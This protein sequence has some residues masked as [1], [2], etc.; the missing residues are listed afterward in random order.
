MT[1]MDAVIAL[2]VGVVVVLFVPAL[3]WSTV[4]AGLYRA[5]RD[6]LRGSLKA[7]ARKEARPSVRAG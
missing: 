7:I 5:V 3:V 6:R 4:I 2:V 1:G